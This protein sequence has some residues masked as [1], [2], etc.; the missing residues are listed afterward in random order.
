MR[1]SAYVH[2][3][4]TVN[5]TGV[6]KHILNMVPRLGRSPD[7]KLEI[8]GARPDL[9]ALATEPAAS[10][11]AGIRVRTYGIRR[12]WMEMAWLLTGASL[13]PLDQ[14]RRLDLLSG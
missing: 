3:H 1:I 14:P 11:L 4:R 7:V 2:L 9:C 8:L 13:R 10:C 5:P 6:G 12:S